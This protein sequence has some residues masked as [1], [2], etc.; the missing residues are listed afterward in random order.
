MKN[1]VL[2]DIYAVYLES[3]LATKDV[4]IKLAILDDM[5]FVNK[6]QQRFPNVIEKFY[7]RKPFTNE[8]FEEMN[9]S[10][11]DLKYEDIERFRDAQLKV[12]HFLHR[13]LDNDASIQ[14][15]Y[16]TALRFFLGFFEKNKIDM[17]FCAHQEHGAIWDSL[18]FEIA[19]SKNIPVYIVAAASTNSEQQMNCITH[20]NKKELCVLNDS[21]K[22]K[23]DSELFFKKIDNYS[24]TY[25]SPS[26]TIFDIAEEQSHKLFYKFNYLKNEVRSLFSNCPQTKYG[27]DKYI[28]QEIVSKAEKCEK[29]VY[30]NKLKN[31][32]NKISVE[33]D[34]NQKY[35]FYPLHL[36]PE[37]T[38]MARSIMTSQLYIIKMISEAL[39]K[40]WK[41]YV[42][43]HPSTYNVYKIV[44]YMYKNIEYFNSFEYYKIIKSMKNVELI[45]LSE[46]VSKLIKESKAVTSICGTALTEAVLA[47]KAIIVW[48][49]GLS[50]VEYLKDAFVASSFS[51]I[52]NSL[53]RL[54]EG[55][56]ADYSDLDD[57]VNKFS[58]V[59]DCYGISDKL[60]DD[61]VKIIKY[62]L[63]RADL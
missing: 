34:Y 25:L 35:I 40:G 14:Y 23:C 30:I 39:P 55:F 56:V 37:A 59:S 46:P 26:K 7:Y 28:H 4:N 20:F 60:N 32:Y 13:E 9:Q 62:L 51:D 48:G 5:N 49:K 18:I 21:G 41:L 19:K 58:F 27:D 61:W 2:I 16:L 54:D 3:M 6:C 43:E 22:S 11:Y 63:N 38:I 10:D 29:E 24:K 45:S 33:A 52:K 57:V 1:V 31:F 15:R 12:E 47:N 50:F 36:E 42:K 53:K 8:E 17:V 44:E